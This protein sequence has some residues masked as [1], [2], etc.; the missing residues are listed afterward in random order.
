MALGEL[1]DPSPPRMMMVDVTD[2]PGA[3]LGDVVTLLGEDPGAVDSRRAGAGG[4]FERSS[5]TTIGVD[6]LARWAGTVN[7]EIMSG[8][9]KRVPRVYRT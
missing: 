2:V 7:Y 1:I 3:S 4:G 9:S 5:A 6:E 8:I